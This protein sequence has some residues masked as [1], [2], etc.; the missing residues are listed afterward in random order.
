MTADH[1]PLPRFTARVIHGSG[2]GKGMGTPTLNLQMQD[3]PPGFPEG[4]YACRARLDGGV[5]LDAAMHYGPRPV[6]KDI[7]SCEVHLLDRN[8]L[9]PP[10]SVEVEVVEYLREVRDFASE[11]EL[12]AQIAK[13]IENTRSIL[14]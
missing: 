12:R 11:D 14:S 5:A 13:D 6:H 7:P 8:V 1:P 9:E 2:R 10:E 4:I 3:V